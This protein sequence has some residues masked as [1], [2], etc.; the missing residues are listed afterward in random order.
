MRRRVFRTF[1]PH[2]LFKS[3]RRLPLK[4]PR[5]HFY[6][7]GGNFYRLPALINLKSIVFVSHFVLFAEQ[8]REI[9][10]KFGKIKL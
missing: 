5:T 4:F 2:M 9:F 1:P 7:L 8:T 10:V 3:N 6:I